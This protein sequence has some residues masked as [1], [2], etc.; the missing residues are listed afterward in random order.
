MSATEIL[1][2]LI[3]FDTTNPPGNEKACVLFIQ[4]MLE[5]AGIETQLY[6]LDENRPNLVAKLPGRGEAPP[7]M[8]YGHVD[9]VTTEGQQWTYPP[10][11]GVIA[12]GFIWGRGTLD[13]KGGIA[14]MLAAL[15]KAKAEGIRPAGDVIFLVLTDEEHNGTYGADFMVKEHP[16]V[17]EGVKYALGEFG[18]FNIEIAGHRFYPVEVAEKQICSLEMTVFGPGGHGSSIVPNNALRKAAKVIERINSHRLPVHIT[19]AVRAMVEGM[20]ESIGFPMGPIF[21]LL[22]NPALTDWML[23]RLGSVGLVL[24]PMFHNTV[25]ATIIQGGSKI[26]VIPSEISI[27]LDGRML[28]GMRPE[29]M[30]AELRELIGFGEED[31]RIDL[32]LYEEGPAEVGME[33]FET[34]ANALLEMDPE[35]KPV[36]YLLTAVTDGRILARLGVQSYG[37][38]PMR[39]P[40]DFEFFKMIHAEDERVPLDAI[41]FGMEGIY[42]VIRDY[43]G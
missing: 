12:D 18:G 25:S 28:P 5:E 38:T 7:L 42:R 29:E 34:L 6:A 10:F 9:V 13:M 30:I 8:L 35:G 22:L 37:F 1:Q 31:V 2:Q 27:K 17:F 40:E 15:L 20:A 14:M 41:D 4:K 3:R 23:D 21:K 24:L 36:P 16:E 39:L 26:N 11:D 19:P 33:L 43:K 32:L